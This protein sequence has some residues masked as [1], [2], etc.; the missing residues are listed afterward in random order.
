VAPDYWVGSV[1]LVTVLNGQSHPGDVYQY[2]VLPRQDVTFGW[3]AC[4]RS[5]GMPECQVMNGNP[6]PPCGSTP[7]FPR[8]FS[9][10]TCTQ[11]Y[12]M[13]HLVRGP[14]SRASQQPTGA[15]PTWGTN[16]LMLSATGGTSA[17]NL[18]NRECPWHTKAQQPAPAK[19]FI[20]YFL[21]GRGVQR[22]AAAC[23]LITRTNQ[24][25]KVWYISGKLGPLSL[26]E[27][28]A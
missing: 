7:I 22:A 17:C 19:C 6:V 24:K 18:A 16:S 11:S 25:E 14:S 10:E 28:Y 26:V 5:D 12:G 27:G 13:P 3:P 20:L 4:T 1:E 21:P 8:P 9:A 2:P 23:H 15:L